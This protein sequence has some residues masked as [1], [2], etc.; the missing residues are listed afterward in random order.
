[1]KQTIKQTINKLFVVVAVATI[2]TGAVSAQQT[3]KNR[4]QFEQL[5]RENSQIQTTEIQTNIAATQNE[6]AVTPKKNLTNQDNFNLG[7]DLALAK[8]D[9]SGIGKN[10]DA[11]SYTILDLVYLIDRFEDQPE[12]AN[13][14]AILKSVV[15]ETADSDRVQKDIDMVFKIYL[16]RQNAGQKWYLN[17]GMTSMNL[18][19]A[20]YFGEDAGIKK[21]LSELQAL[22]KIAPKGTP[23]EIIDPM[24][25]LAKYVTKTAFTEE[26][27]IAIF[28]GVGNV[29]DAATA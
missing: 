15:R 20:T 23:K 11:A 17:A 19:I 9:A 10:E 16:K 13:L 21:G 28:D 25:V 6:R 3:Q 12:A 2:L 8:F 5:I 26:D 1:M 4:E 18:S 14:K 7:K 22:I 27:Y 24:N 29:M